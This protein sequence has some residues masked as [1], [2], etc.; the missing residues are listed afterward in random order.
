M[1]DRPGGRWSA[2]RFVRGW[3]F[4]WQCIRL[5]FEGPWALA[6]VA[7]S[8]LGLF[9]PLY[10][11]LH[12]E[13]AAFVN[14]LLWQIP[15]GI[16]GG[17]SAIRLLLS[18]FWV[19]EAEIKTHETAVAVIAGQADE[20]KGKLGALMNR[21][22]ARETLAA[23]L[24]E[25]R[26]LIE[27]CAAAEKPEDYQP[28]YDDANEWF[29]RLHEFLLSELDVSYFQAL[30]TPVANGIRLPKNSKVPDADLLWHRLYDF[31]ARLTEFISSLRD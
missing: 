2:A 7:S 16:L 13:E 25:S 23:F 18:P 9:V 29:R 21:R 22:R 26:P 6:G 8:L 30:Q 14:D 10:L 1:A 5:A 20:L 17:L 15:L 28:I 31:R 24:S 4:Y 19:H 3:N 12:P 11:K 27:R